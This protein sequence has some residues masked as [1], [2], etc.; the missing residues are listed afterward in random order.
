MKIMLT[1]S[2]GTIGTRLF[3]Q[4]LNLGYDVVG[5]DWKKNNWNRSLNNRTFLVNL[6]KQSDLRKLPTGIDLI[7][8]FA[9]NSRVYDLVKNP[10][11]ALE[12]LVTTFNVLCFAENAHIGRIIFSSSREVYG[13]S[14]DESLITEDDARIES[15]ESPYSASKVSGEAFIHAYSK[16]FGLGFVIIRFSNVYGMYDNTDRVIPLWIRQSAGNENLVVYGKNKVLDFTYIDDAVHGAVKVIEQFDNVKSETFNI[17]SCEKGYALTYVANRIRD[18]V[19][20]KSKIMLTD[21][22][23][24]EVCKFQADITKAEKLLGYKSKVSLEEGLKKTIEWYKQ[25]EK[26]R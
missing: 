2:S 21:N 9:A 13:N 22:R 1:G 26:R 3:E 23:S 8:H 16:T 18:L 14:V 24:G 12:N 19:G 25:F 11:L 20:S 5:V 15:S 4:L 7:I 6:L 10:A 17:A